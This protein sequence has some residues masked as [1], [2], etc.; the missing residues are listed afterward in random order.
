MIV[1][2]ALFTV[3][4]ALTARGLRCGYGYKTSKALYIA[5]LPKEGFKETQCE[6]SIFC[7]EVV[8]DPIDFFLITDAMAD[9]KFCDEEFGVF[10]EVFTEKST[11]KL[12]LND[13]I[14]CAKYSFNTS[15]VPGLL[16]TVFATFCC[17]KGELCNCNETAPNDANLCDLEDTSAINSTYFEATT[18]RASQQS[19]Y[20]YF[21][22]TSSL[23]FTIY[24][25]L[26][27]S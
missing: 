19:H 24:R 13:E 10:G 26:I 21:L 12:L 4:L 11:C 15:S 8:T 6:S 25:F 9:F 22:V 23:S 20:S 27:A 3:V 7:V 16:S 1:L 5:D 14:G 2:F 17:C 18:L